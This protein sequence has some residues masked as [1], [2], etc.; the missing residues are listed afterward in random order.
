MAL[1]AKSP[2]RLHQLEEQ[3]DGR[4]QLGELGKGDV[5]VRQGTPCMLVDISLA[6]FG[7]LPC[8]PGKVW[9]V[10]LQNGSTWPCSVAEEV[11]PAISPLLSYKT[12]RREY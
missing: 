1:K 7:S 2:Y 11:F 4:L 6:P 8:D 12:R 5:F 3:A 10:N 9:V